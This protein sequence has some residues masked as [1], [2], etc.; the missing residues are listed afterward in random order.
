[1]YAPKWGPGQV[2]QGQEIPIFGAHVY[3]SRD[4]PQPIPDHV[5]CEACVDT[6]DSAVL[7]DHDGSFSLTVAPGHYWFVIQKG[8]FRLEQE[9]DVAI[10]TIDAAAAV[11][12]AAVEARTA[13]TARGSRRIAI[14]HGNYDAVERHPRQDRLR[15][16]ERR[17][18][19]AHH[20]RR[21]RRRLDVEI[22]FYDYET[23]G[24]G[25][26]AVPGRRTSTR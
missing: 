9:I 20:G 4:K 11:D 24:D 7:S 15:H 13:R 17:E 25:S 6:P 5:Y 18:E 2:P 21:R 12:D 26:V 22:T 16:D 19:S 8:Q 10:G 3:V 1:M 14:A 23:T